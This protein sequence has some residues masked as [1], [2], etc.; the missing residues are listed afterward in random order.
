[1]K[2]NPKSSRYTSALVVITLLII[3]AVGRVGAAQEATRAALPNVY[4]A[5]VPIYPSVAH[6]A[7]V[8]GVVRV[9]V[10]TDGHAVVSTS[11]ENQDVN[12]TLARAAQDNLQTW[13]FSAGEPTTFTVTY[14]YVLAAKLK[15]IKSNASNSKVVIRFPTDVEVSAQRWPEGGDIHVHLKTGQ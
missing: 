9:K 5:A 11:V 12:P 3:T 15:D 6:M 14:R 13:K 2:N 7:N 4:V 10:I 8:Q 1:M